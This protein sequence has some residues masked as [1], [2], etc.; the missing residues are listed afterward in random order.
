KRFKLR[1]GV[2]HDLPVAVAAH[3]EPHER[4][5]LALR[6]WS[7]PSG[8]VVC[9]TILASALSNPT[10]NVRHD[11]IRYPHGRV[12]LLLLIFRWNH[13]DRDL[14]QTFLHLRARDPTHGGVDRARRFVVARYGTGIGTERR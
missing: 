5:R 1:G 7:P 4:C 13:G 9:G 3:H 14:Q 6:H 2:A 8:F 10:R 11:V 12:A